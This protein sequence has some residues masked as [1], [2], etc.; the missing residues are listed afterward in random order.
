[1]LEDRMKNKDRKKSELHLLNN[2]SSFL[3]KA[4]NKNFCVLKGNKSLNV[5]CAF[6][7]NIFIYNNYNININ[8][9]K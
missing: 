2:W 3:I 1:M 4:K 5:F 7:S 6:G 9:Q 8:Y